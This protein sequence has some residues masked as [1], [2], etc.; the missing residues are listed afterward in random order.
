[1]AFDSKRLSE[2]TE[3]AKQAGEFDNPGVKRLLGLIASG[4]ASTSIFKI[5]DFKLRRKAAESTLKGDS[6]DHHIITQEE[7]D[8]EVH[9]GTIE[10]G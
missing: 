5:L 9:I 4:V 3:L 2:Y 6:F 10:I 1:M 8:G 7:L